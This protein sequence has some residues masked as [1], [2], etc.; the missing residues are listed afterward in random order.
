VPLRERLAGRLQVRM[1][2]LASCGDSRLGAPSSP[3][4]LFQLFDVGERGVVSRRELLS[5]VRRLGLPVSYSLLSAPVS[6][7]Y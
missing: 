4:A 1:E 5:C 6:F 2:E 7:F 3:L